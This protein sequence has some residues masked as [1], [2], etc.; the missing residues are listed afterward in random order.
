MGRTEEAERRTQASTEAEAQDV[1]S[2]TS[3]AGGKSG[4][5][6]SSEGCQERCCLTAFLGLLSILTGSDHG[7]PYRH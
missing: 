6:T 5:G 2:R 3:E 1:T 4:E 7:R